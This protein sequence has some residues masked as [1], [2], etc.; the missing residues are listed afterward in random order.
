MG[1]TAVGDLLMSVKEDCL[2]FSCYRSRDLL[3]S[4]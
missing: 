3:E 1:L 4:G 2:L